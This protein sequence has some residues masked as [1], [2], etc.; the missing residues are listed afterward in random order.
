M[1]QQAVLGTSLRNNI[2]GH[3]DAVRFMFNGDQEWIKLYDRTSATLGEARVVGRGLGKLGPVKQ[4]RKAINIVEASRRIGRTGRPL[5]IEEASELGLTEFLNK[6][7]DLGDGQTLSGGELLMAFGQGELFGTFAARGFAGAPS[8]TGSIKALRKR[9]EDI[10]AGSKI[11]A[12]E[13]QLRGTA[14]MSE[15]VS[16]VAA[17]MGRTREGVPL[18]TAIEEVK[19]A[20]VD[21]NQLTKI[22]RAG[23]K[24]IFTYYTFARHYVPFFMRQAAQKPGGFAKPGAAMR[25][26]GAIGV[27]DGQVNAR[28]GDV[29]VNLQRANANIDAMMSIPAI[30]ERF[31]GAGR[32]PEDISGAIG[33]PGFLS[34][35]GVGSVVTG[36]EDFFTT[37][38]SR[39]RRDWLTNAAH[40][41]FATRWI[42]EGVTGQSKGFQEELLRFV[43]PAKTVDKNQERRTLISNYQ[44][45]LRQIQS[46]ARNTKS[47]WRRKQLVEESR[48]LS[49]A[50]RGFLQEES[51]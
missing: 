5:S 27:T 18:H 6:T 7:H 22:E 39:P 48:G 46:D 30:A 3:M 13:E 33:T 28:V 44:R 29:R 51:R 14:E 45:L 15:T 34:T 24:R 25:N 23:L 37:D 4:A 41:T 9:G 20:F 35:G 38:N 12:G 1:F 19:D 17:V 40:S 50:L 2:G 31:F 47:A 36:A 49:V 10:F 21:Y 8:T 42:H 16:R 43:A 26:F 11:K 32:G